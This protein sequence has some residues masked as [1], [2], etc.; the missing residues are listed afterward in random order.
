M[1]DHIFRLSMLWSF[2]RGNIYRRRQREVLCSYYQ[3]WR[4]S[5]RHKLDMVKHRQS[6]NQNNYFIFFG[7]DSVIFVSHYL[8]YWDWQNWNK[9]VLY[10][11]RSKKKRNKRWKNK[12]SFN[13]KEFGSNL[14]VYV[15]TQF[16]FML[17]CFTWSLSLSFE[18]RLVQKYF[19][20]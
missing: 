1:D 2:I 3:L 17:V 13:E 14:N 12:N 18:L 7:F 8:F 15:K 9:W 4:L 10:E 6:K 16:L 20:V 11:K 5:D 19:I